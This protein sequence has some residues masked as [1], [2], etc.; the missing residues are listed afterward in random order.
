LWADRA[1]AN[2][3]HES[4]VGPASMC[5]VT[6]ILLTKRGHGGSAPRQL[7]R[8]R[9]SPYQFL[10]PARPFAPSSQRKLTGFT[11]GF[12]LSAIWP[13]PLAEFILQGRR[14]PGL[15]WHARARWRDGQLPPKPAP[16]RASRSSPFLIRSRSRVCMSRQHAQLLARETRRLTSSTSSAGRAT[17][18]D[19]AAMDA[20][21]GF[22]A[23]RSDL[24]VIDTLGHCYS[25]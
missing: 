12:C 7:I 20:V 1:A 14:C 18:H 15:L 5:L 8:K 17:L 3:D 16:A 9:E 22:Y 11:N 4:E 21:K 13:R 19:I 6:G 24:V 2:A 23:V 10:N 25:S